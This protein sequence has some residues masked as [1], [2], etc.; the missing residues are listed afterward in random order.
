MDV[1]RYCSVL[2]VTFPSITSHRRLTDLVTNTL[3][4]EVGYF[5][6]NFISEENF[7]KKKKINYSLEMIKIIFHGS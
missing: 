6:K 7:I 1:V 2:P 4:Y 3:D 5:S